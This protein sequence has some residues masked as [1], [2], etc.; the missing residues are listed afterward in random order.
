MRVVRAERGLTLVEMLVVLAIIGIASGVVVLG[1]GSGR[2]VNV[3]AEA[4]TMANRLALASDIELVQDRRLLMAWD[5]RGY[6]FLGWDPATR[7]WLPETGTSLAGRHSLPTGFR[8]AI[9]GTS[10]A[11]LTSDGTGQGFAAR[12]SEGGQNGRSWQVL[13]DGFVAV[14][15][16]ASA[17]KTPATT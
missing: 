13:F 7:R 10:P 1:F 6:S 14:A 2:G 11:L 12:I 8:L 9:D 15:V 5:D 16:P 17:A 3:Q 4:Q